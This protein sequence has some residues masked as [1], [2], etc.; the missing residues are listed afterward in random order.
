MNKKAQKININ[1]PL[2]AFLAAILIIAVFGTVSAVLYNL[3]CANEKQKIS[4][5][6]AIIV[7]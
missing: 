2:G 7:G 6:E 5:L 4:Q 3:S 1:T